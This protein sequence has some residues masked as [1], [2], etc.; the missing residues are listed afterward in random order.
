MTTIGYD[1]RLHRSRAT[2]DGNE[3]VELQTGPFAQHYWK[4]DSCYV[5]ARSFALVDQPLREFT[6]Y[7]DIYSTLDVGGDGVAPC[8]AAWRAVAQQIEAGD[9]LAAVRALGIAQLPL[10]DGELS[11]QAPQVVALLNGLAD[12]FEQVLRQHPRAALV[13]L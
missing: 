7:V 2:L 9:V 13:G 11:L 5:L 6:D 1:F 3:Y 12:H 8:C 4:D 10:I